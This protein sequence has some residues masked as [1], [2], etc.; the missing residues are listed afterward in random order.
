MAKKPYFSVIV[1]LF[2]EEKNIAKLHQEILM[3][4]KSLEKPYEIIFVDDGSND[5]SFQVLRKLK[6]LKTIRFRRNFGQSAALDAGIKNSQGE[7]L[8]TLDGDG[9]N[10]PNDIPKLLKKLNEKYDA[11]CGWRY[12]R[13]D[14]L[15]KKIISKFANYIGSF[16]VNP[17]VH[18]SGCTLRVYKRECF[19]DFDLYGEMHRMIPALIRW[20]GFKITE[21]KV[22]HKKRKFGKTK[23]TLTRTLKGSLDMFEVWFWR[24][25]ENR[26]LHLFGGLGI[27]LSFFSFAFGIYLAI[28]RIFFAYSLANKIWPLIAVTGFITGIQFLI[29]GLLA[30][31]IIKN[32][33]K[34]DFYRIK[35]IIER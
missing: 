13:K 12:Q 1:P 33:S 25:Y 15:S 8:I 19:E 24:K 17:G 6:P 30:D 32:R 31:L 16:L 18:D 7:I 9:Q 29:F 4:M 35:E 28:R 2:N 20:R 27:L 26:P 3:V 34:K 10:D 21:V 5:N 14:P 11:V 23:Y 22:N